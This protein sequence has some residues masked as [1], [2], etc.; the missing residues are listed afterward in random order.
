MTA[1]TPKRLE[2]VA[3]ELRDEHLARRNDQE[4][5]EGELSSSALATATAVTALAISDAQR[6]SAPVDQG[7]RWITD[8]VNRDGG[9]GRGRGG[10]L[11]AADRKGAESMSGA[12]RA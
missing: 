1:V 3:R 7:I 6:F 2:A 9:W 8:N 4:F 10:P 12:Q 11:G 5:W